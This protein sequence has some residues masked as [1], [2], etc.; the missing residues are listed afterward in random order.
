MH[1][2]AADGIESPPREHAEALPGIRRARRCA[3]DLLFTQ[4]ARERGEANG[5]HGRMPS[6]RRSHAGRGIT[7]EQLNM[8]ETGRDGI[9]DILDGEILVE[10]DELLAPWVEAKR[11]RMS[12]SHCVAIDRSARFPQVARAGAFAISDHR[13]EREA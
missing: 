13:I 1:G 6:L 8:V 2:A 9:P 7:F 5:I 11:Q 4:P 3:A 10:I 12:S